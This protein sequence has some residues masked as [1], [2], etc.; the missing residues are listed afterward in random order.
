[1]ELGGSSPLGDLRESAAYNLLLENLCDFISA[2]LA[3]STWSKYSSGWKALEDYEKFC[4][5]NLSF[6]LSKEHLRGF[7]TFCLSVKKIQP[8]STRSY[9]SAIT[10]LHRIKGFSNFE[11]KDDIVSA[12]LKGAGNL[13]MSSD[14]PPS[15]TR[16]AMSLQLLKHLGHRLKRTN[17]DPLTIQTIWT[18]CTVAFFSSA[19][20][21]ELLSEEEFN[22]DASAT[23]TWSCVKLRADGSILL[24][25]R[26]PKSSNKEGD[27]LDIFEFK[28]HNVCPVKAI[29]RLISMQDKPISRLSTVPVF[30]LPNGKF[31]TT[32]KLNNILQ[33]LFSDICEPGK[34]S[35]SCHS[36]R[37][38]V[39]SVLNKF[40]ELASS[41]DIKGWGRWNSDCFQRYTRLRI[42]QKKKIF[43]KITWALSA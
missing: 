8:S 23:L 2:S 11:I 3:K 16:R 32:K 1:L 31:L 20:M 6:P 4:S 22:F 24:H 19:R 36:F 41:D 39:P 30:T 10:A 26:Q 42:D 37:A 34:N 14:S 7:A 33:S 18:A 25:L 17:W 27:F 15:S 12:A 9:L 5:I 13:V 28:G 29:N 43:A 40:P 38:G 21:G 35:I